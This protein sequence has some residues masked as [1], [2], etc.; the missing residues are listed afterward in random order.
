[1]NERPVSPSCRDPDPAAAAAAGLSVS[2]VGADE[3]AG[4]RPAWETLAESALE[5]N[6]FY[7]PW[8][9]LPALRAFGAG[10]GL[11]LVAVRGPDPARPRAAPLLHG[12][13]PLQRRRY[14][15]LFPCLRLWQYPHC[16]L[17]APLLRA[18]SADAALTA[19]LDWLAASPYRRGLLELNLVPGDGPLHRCLSDLLSRRGVTPFVAGAWTRAVQRPAADAD[20]YLRGVLSGDGRRALKRRAARLADLGPVE[21]VAPPPGGDVRPWLEGFLKAEAGGWKGRQ[22]TALACDAAGRAFFLE[23]AAEAF[24]RGRLMLFTLRVGGTAVAWRCNLL[25]G[26]ACFAFKTAYDEAFA[27]HS[28]GALLEAENV[29]RLHALPGRPWMDSCT[30]PDNELLNRMSNDRRLMQSLVVA[31]GPGWPEWLVASLPL[32]RRARRSFFPSSPRGPIVKPQPR[33]KGTDMATVTVPA[34]AERPQP[35]ATAGRAL[36]I[37]PARFR[38]DFNQKPFLVRHNLV[39]HPLFTLPALIDLFKRLPEGHVEYYSGNVP[40]SQDWEKT[41]RTGLSVEETIRRIEECCSWLFLKRVELDPEYRAFLDRFLDEVQ[42]QTDHI[43]R[44]MFDRQAAIFVSSPNAVTPYHMDDEHNFLLQMRGR[45]TIHVFPGRDRTLLSEEELE[46]HYT[47][48]S[49]DRNLKFK[50][51]YQAKAWSFDLQTG[52]ALHIPE[53]YPHWVQNGDGVSISFSCGFYTPCCERRKLV[54]QLNRKLRR[55]GLRPTPYGQSPWRD[56]VKHSLARAGRWFRARL[57]GK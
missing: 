24:R 25:A 47:R 28:P 31:A 12:L 16:F 7:E 50:D 42:E 48:T 9:L 6:V 19:F 26:G 10:A 32:L 18:A 52:Y 36:E 39:G 54:H 44:G 23:A 43:D 56:G 34:A 35:S 20:A 21:W 37:E 46:A 51:E 5:P 2:V 22:G 33:S 41:P 17:C 30:D 55:W 13:F 3:L 45:K 15:R 49:Y 4:L 27:R 1:V 14:R 8:M 38:A 29:R 11:R 53:M 57:G 40:V